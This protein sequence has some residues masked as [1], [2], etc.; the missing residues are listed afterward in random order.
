MRAGPASS[1]ILKYKI[2]IELNSGQLLQLTLT[3][4]CAAMALVAGVFFLVLRAAHRVRGSGWFWGFALLSAGLGLE[5]GGRAVPVQALACAYAASICA[6]AAAFCTVKASFD[7]VQKDRISSVALWTLCVSAAGALTIAGRGGLTS[8]LLGPELAMAAATGI[9]AFVLYPAARQTRKPGVQTAVG[10]SALLT[11]VQLRTLLNAAV[12]GAAGR[13][14]NELY[15]VLESIAIGILAFVLA[16]G[17]LVAI[18]DEIRVE[19]E[20]TNSALNGAM[21]GLEA[22][23]KMDPLTGLLNRYAFHAVVAELRRTRTFDG[24]IVALDLNGLKRINDTFGH[25]A[26]DRALQSVARRLQE[27]VRSS[28]YVFRW[29]GDEFVLLLFDVLP[30]VAR[31]RLARMDAPEPLHLHGRLP[32]E[33]SVSWGVAP[34]A[35]EVEAALKEADEQLYSQRRLIRNAAAKLGPV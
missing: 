6:V 35:Y 23:A 19:L 30:E 21:E 27:M 1:D 33:L 7:F 14:L 24:S 26:G 4:F 22:A 3:V 8:G 32:V 25:Y 11:L 18:L 10:A 16:M 20:E 17:Q 28:D 9:T 34:L 5:A 12:L 13:Q 31:D 15:W 29:G 2:V